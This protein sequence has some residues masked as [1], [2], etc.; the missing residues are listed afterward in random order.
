MTQNLSQHTRPSTAVIT[1]IAKLLLRPGHEQNGPGQYQLA[2]YIASP[3]H[4]DPPT[5]LRPP[6]I[7]A[8][9][10]SQTA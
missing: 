6:S 2:L 3:S 8:A 5:P 1:W 4:E 7:P 9:S 10:W